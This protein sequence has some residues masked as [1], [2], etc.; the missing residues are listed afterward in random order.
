MSRHHKPTGATNPMTTK[1]LLMFAATT[2]RGPVAYEGAALA[3]AATAVIVPAPATY[4]APTDNGQ[5]RRTLEEETPEMA[6][7][8]ILKDPTTGKATRGLY[9]QM[10]TELPPATGTTTSRR[11]ND[12]VQGA[13]TL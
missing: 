10:Q 13:L 5:L 8:V 7:V 2:L 6:S 9:F 12:R 1:T 3:G 11:A 4:H